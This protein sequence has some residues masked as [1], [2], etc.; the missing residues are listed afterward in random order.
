MTNSLTKFNRDSWKQSEKDYKKLVKHSETIVDSIQEMLAQGY[1][2]H[3]ITAG[4]KKKH[5]L[6]N[7]LASQ[8]VHATIVVAHTFNPDY[9][10]EIMSQ[11]RL[12]LNMTLRQ[13]E[14]MYKQADD[15]R[16]QAQ[17]LMIKLKAL[18]QLR[19]L[20]PKQIQLTHVDQ[21]AEDT[22]RQLIEVYGIDVEDPDT[23]IEANILCE[24][25]E[26]V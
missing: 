7:K 17:A 10:L 14:Q 26:G 1:D 2:R 24:D 22:K 5:D 3:Q 16:D 12:A 6:T 9:A 18:N 21:S 20:V 15:S 25:V 13:A 8:Y 4:I 11:A 19:D 23:I